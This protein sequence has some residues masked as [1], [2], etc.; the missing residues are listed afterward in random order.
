[1]SFLKLVD[2]AELDSPFEEE[3][4][5]DTL[6]KVGEWVDNIDESKL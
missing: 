1:M 4:V 5:K 2:L 6:A 3:T